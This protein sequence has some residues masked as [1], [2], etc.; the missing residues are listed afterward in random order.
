MMCGSHTNLVCPDKLTL[1]DAEPKQHYHRNMQGKR[2]KADLTRGEILN[3]AIKLTQCDGIDVSM[4]DLAEELDTWPNTIYAFF[5]NKARLKQ[6]IVNHLLDRAFDDEMLTALAGLAMP[7]RDAFEQ[8][9]ITLF[10]L[11]S[12]YRGLAPLMLTQGAG[13]TS[14]AMLLVPALVGRLTREGLDEEKAAIIMHTAIN[15]VLSLG[16][17]VALYEA[18]LTAGETLD[19]AMEHSGGMPM[20]ITRQV[21]FDYTGPERVESGL[22]I[23]VAAIEKELGQ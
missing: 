19:T 5:E 12:Q 1:L 4:R 9:G 11:A 3:A 20:S 10:E 8:A 14:R 6:A 22:A 2:T 17:T 15:Y 23:F 13:T 7:W 18:G 16:Q 21:F